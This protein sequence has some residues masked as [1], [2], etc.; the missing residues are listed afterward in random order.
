MISWLR[1]VSR[2]PVGSS[3]TSSVGRVTMARAIA[4]RCCWPPDSS[5]GVC[6]SRPSSPTS[7][8]AFMRELAALA[9]RDA[10]IDQRQLDILG[11]RGARQQ[12]V[13]LEDEADIEVA[14]RR[15]AAAVEPPAS[16][17]RKP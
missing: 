10:A 17:S 15:A 8:S 11:G 12:I 7:A 2:L 9:G 5:A 13:A 1:A 4:T 16:T 14:Q 6:V 3:A